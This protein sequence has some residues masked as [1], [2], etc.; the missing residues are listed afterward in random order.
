MPGSGADQCPE[1][2]GVVQ[3]LRVNRPAV[4]HR[5]WR[6]AGVLLLEDLVDLTDPALIT[7][8]LN[9]G[10]VV[11][12]GEAGAATEL[13]QILGREAAAVFGRLVREH[14]ATQLIKSAR[15]GSNCQSVCRPYR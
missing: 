4:E 15:A 7:A 12:A 2:G 10:D 11:G 9:A 1:G 5:E 8:L 6:A 3:A 14:L 13:Q